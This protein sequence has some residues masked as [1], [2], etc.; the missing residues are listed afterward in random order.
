[1][2]VIPAAG[3]LSQQCHLKLKNKLFLLLFS[4]IIYGF[5][6][7][8]WCKVQIPTGDEP[9]FLSIT[10]ALL[11]KGDFDVRD[12]YENE[13]YRAF[14]PAALQKGDFHLWYGTDPNATHWY[15]SHDV[16]LPVLV[17]PAYWGGMQIGRLRIVRKFIEKH[18]NTHYE[19]Y[20]PRVTV[21]LFMS[22]LMA[23]IS[24]NVFLGVY[25]I[26]GKRTVAF[27]TWALVSFTYPMISFASQIYPETPIALCLIFG[28][29]QIL[30]LRQSNKRYTLLLIGTVTALLPWFHIKALVLAIMFFGITLIEIRPR[31]KQWFDW[32]SNLAY[33]CIPCL[34]AGV[35]F[36]YS[37]LVWFG[38]V[39][40]YPVSGFIWNGLK[41][42]MAGLLF[43]QHYGILPRAPI[44][45]LA[46]LG[47]IVGWR[48]KAIFYTA[49]IS[50]FIWFMASLFSFWGAGAFPS[51]YL[52]PAIPLLSLPLGWAILQFG[53]NIPFI[54]IVA[55][56]AIW[57]FL[58]QALLIWDVYLL[59]SSKGFVFCS[60]TPL[61]PNFSSLTRINLQLFVSWLIALLGIL[62]YIYF[63]WRIEQ[64]LFQRKRNITI[65]ITT[66]L[67]LCLVP[68][69]VSAKK[70]FQDNLRNLQG[71]VQV[72][73]SE[74][75][76]RYIGE[77]VVAPEA[78]NGKIVCSRVRQADPSVG[79]FLSLGPFIPLS[80]GRYRLTC[81]LS[82][83][84]LKGNQAVVSVFVSSGVGRKKHA[85]KTITSNEFHKSGVFQDFSVE[86]NS[87]GELNFEFSVYVHSKENVCIDRMEIRYIGK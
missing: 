40:N 56:L 20:I 10:L 61:F 57:G 52:V 46:I 33:L 47:I 4:L 37:H 42:G 39:M 27:I 50:V 68:M 77:I 69:T 29:R 43:D 82:A 87:S 53:K 44:Y 51:R 3:T 6:A 18:Y 49:G 17:S 21:S 11:T 45:M 5:A 19:N 48:K 7:L 26:I 67:V 71:M 28:L 63:I 9:H 24:L 32:V 35:L 1:M 80:S 34:I 14:Y 66:A 54:L 60:L 30:H 38:V 55:I 75:M 41:L 16:G 73:E 64:G 76:P 2:N 59:F 84:Q 22:F 31:G 25:E 72:Y 13:R 36:V 86:F 15:S 81:W 79:P 62:G 65:V 70:S 8:Q 12:V 83:D 85:E 58:V 74:N 23:L 78:S